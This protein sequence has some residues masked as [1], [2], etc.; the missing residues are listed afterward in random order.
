MRLVVL[1]NINTKEQQNESGLGVV[2]SSLL[3]NKKC[4]KKSCTDGHSS[5]GLSDAGVVL[6]KLSYQADWELVVM[7]LDYKPGD[8]NFFVTT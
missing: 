3:S 8:E 6:Y 5:P 4:L 1:I 7:W 2:E